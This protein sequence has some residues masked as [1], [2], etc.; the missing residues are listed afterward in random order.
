VNQPALLAGNHFLK[1]KVNNLVDVT[2]SNYKPG[3]MTKLLQDP[4]MV[5][6]SRLNA[7]EGTGEQHAAHEDSI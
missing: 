7:E 1:G 5:R 2:R 3:N 6:M 4:R